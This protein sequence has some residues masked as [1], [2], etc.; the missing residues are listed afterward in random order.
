MKK[1]IAAAVA[2]A[3]IAPAFAADVSVSGDVEFVFNDAEAGN[4]SSTGDADIRVSASEE[5]D[6][7]MT[8][9]VYIDFEDENEDSTSGLNENDTDITISGP[10]GTLDIGNNTD[11]GGDTF[12]DVADVAENGLGN[13]LDAAASVGN[14]VHFMPNLGVEGLAI[15]IGYA[16]GASADNAVVGYGI[17]YATG[18]LTVAAGQLS[19]DSHS[20][21]DGT[22]VSVSY[23]TGP[24]Y[25][26]YEARDNTDGTQDKEE[27]SMALTYNYGPGK[28][29]VEIEDSQASA[30]AEELTDTVIGA[31]YKLGGAVNMYLQTKKDE[32]SSTAETDTTTFGVEYSF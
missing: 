31:S 12:D 22:H 3:F 30:S 5:M 9:S 21:D 28:L 25:A 23:A 14:S 2:T 32:T 18:G 8:V 13:D 17:Q 11:L 19:D 26:A 29:Y 1:I 6:N 27:T 20:N 15:A 7:G 4:S 24:F 16:H 10:F